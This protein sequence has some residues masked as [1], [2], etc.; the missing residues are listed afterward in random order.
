MFNG[1]PVYK[2]E[3]SAHFFFYSH[4]GFWLVDS[5]LGGSGMLSSGLSGLRVPAATGWRYFENGR[6]I[7]ENSLTWRAEYSTPT[8]FVVTSAGGTARAVGNML[9]LYEV[10]NGTHQDRPVYKMLGGD[11][12]LY[13]SDTKHWMVGPEVG[14]SVGFIRTLSTGD[15]ESPLVGWSVFNGKGWV[16]DQ[17]LTVEPYNGYLHAGILHE[18][19]DTK[20][21]WNDHGTHAE[22]DFSC[23][24]P[25]PPNPEFVLLGSIPQNT[26]KKPWKGFVFHSA[27]KEAF[28]DPIGYKFI[29]NDKGTGADSPSSIWRPICSTGYK[30]VGVFCQDSRRRPL[31]SAMK[32]VH[33]I[34]V[35]A[36]VSEWVWNDENSGS[37][38]QVT[39]FK[40]DDPYLQGMEAISTRSEMFGGSHCLV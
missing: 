40:N 6:W 21:M 30:S 36:C 26:Y 37:P 5:V 17:D 15:M 4:T 32:C 18:Q 11:F 8:W 10:R 35:R 2:L 14:G 7:V 9:G 23:W 12:F 31:L 27:D 38:K 20:E 24:N 29:W 28:K 16:V 13:Y 25:L 3:G 33:E 19:V 1:F 22:N 39:I 34:Y